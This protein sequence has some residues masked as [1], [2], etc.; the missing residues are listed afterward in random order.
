MA[1]V[2]VCGRT[3]KILHYGGVA[4]GVADSLVSSNRHPDGRPTSKT[5]PPLAC[6]RDQTSTA[7]LPRCRVSTEGQAQ[8]IT[9][10][11]KRTP[12][13]HQLLFDLASIVARTASLLRTGRHEGSSPRS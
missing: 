8:A 11:K 3:R 5:Y 12:G 13:Q 7:P 1:A 10:R 6:M 2:C 4:A 9:M